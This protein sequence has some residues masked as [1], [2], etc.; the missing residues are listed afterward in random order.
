MRVERS[1]VYL[2]SSLASNVEASEACTEGWNREDGKAAAAAAAA[3]AE[4]SLEPVKSFP[5]Q[6]TTRTGS[7]LWNSD[8]S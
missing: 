1:F 7:R 5:A 2:A 4:A 3:A 8:G 6:S